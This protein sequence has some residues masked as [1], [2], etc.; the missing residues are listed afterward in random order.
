LFSRREEDEQESPLRIVFLSVEGNKTEEQYFTFVEKYRNQLGIKNGV[1]IHSLKRSK[2][3][4]LSAPE[5]VLELLEE[6]LELRNAECLPER[7]RRAIPSEYSYDF[8]VDYVNGNSNVE[9]NRIIRFEQ[10]LNAVGIDLEYDFFLKEYKGHND[11]FGIV[12]DRDYKSHSLEQMKG[13]MQQCND[14]GYKCFVTNP[15]FEFWLL[16]H[17]TDIK[18][19]FGPDLSEFLINNSVSN[20][21]TFTSEKVSELAGHAK[22]IRE[23]I[24]L[25]YYLPNIDYAIGQARTCFSTNLDELIGNIENTETKK[26]LLGSNLPELF[27]LLRNI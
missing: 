3:D 20:Q 1:H 2:H 25:K 17:L 26:G 24:F 7:L 15:L 22:S 23:S 4:N 8:I 12:I 13:I 18:K 10:L 19:T 16:L 21:H 11:V 5:N 6:Y 9:D 14:K 27:D